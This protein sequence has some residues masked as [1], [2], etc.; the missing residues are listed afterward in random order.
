MR[1][2]YVLMLILA[3]C[4]VGGAVVYVVVREPARPSADQPA[5]VQ[6]TPHNSENL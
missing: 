6:A 1:L 2:R 3:A 5:P 4:A